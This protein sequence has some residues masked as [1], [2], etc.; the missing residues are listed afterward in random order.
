MRSQDLTTLMNPDS[1][2]DQNLQMVFFDHNILKETSLKVVC[3]VRY[4]SL[5]RV[6]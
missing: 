3:S 1:M 5:F 2:Y 4:I 6:L